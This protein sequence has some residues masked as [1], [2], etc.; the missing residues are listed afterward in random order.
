MKNTL[1][2]AQL[3]L[4][5][6]VRRE[7]NWFV[8]EGE[9]HFV[10]AASI[11][12]AAG[13]LLG[14]FFSG[15]LDGLKDALKDD[16]KAAGKALGAFLL[17][18][19]RA[20]TSGEVAI[21]PGHVANT[22]LAAQTAVQSADPARTAAVFQSMEEGMRDSFSEVMPENRATALAAKVR[23]TGAGVLASPGQTS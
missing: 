18:R 13:T 2:A 17:A 3:E 23:E 19:L 21:E 20:I 9:K 22:A 11:G 1:E 10:A 16:G 4:E 6:D 14:A 8:P 15:V 5:A 12:I 7:I